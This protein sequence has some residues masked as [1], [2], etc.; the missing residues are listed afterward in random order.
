[1]RDFGEPK[2]VY[3]FERDRRDNREANEEDVGLGVAEGANSVVV[4]LSCL[5]INVRKK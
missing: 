4:L 2:R 3:S 1:M 5:L